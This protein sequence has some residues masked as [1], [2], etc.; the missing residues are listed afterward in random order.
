MVERK[1]VIGVVVER[2]LV[3][4]VV[5]QRELVVCLVVERELVQLGVG[6]LRRGR[7]IRGR[8]SL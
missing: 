5:V 2:K 4:G 8:V 6:G 3:V 7:R 1:L